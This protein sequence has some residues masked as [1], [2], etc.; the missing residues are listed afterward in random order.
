MK[1]QDINVAQE[2]YNKYAMDYSHFGP[3]EHLRSSK[4]QQ[5]IPPLNLVDYKYCN[6]V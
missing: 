4:N 5:R 1:V 2:D 3:L 6:I